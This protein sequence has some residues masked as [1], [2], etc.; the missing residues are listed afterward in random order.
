MDMSVTDE[1]LS[2]N[3]VKKF[4]APLDSLVMLNGFGGEANKISYTI[5]DST[6]STVILAV[7]QIP[8]HVL[9]SG[10]T[11]LNINY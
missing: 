8:L 7:A 11:P 4:P 2:T 1:S 5:Y 3:I 9:N 10:R 6:R